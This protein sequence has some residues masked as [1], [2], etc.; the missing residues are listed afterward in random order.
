MCNLGPYK[1]KRDNDYYYHDWPISYLV[2]T[3]RI[4]EILF[5]F[6]TPSCHNHIPFRIR[7]VNC[8]IVRCF[9]IRPQFRNYT[10]AQFTRY[11]FASSYRLM[12]TCLFSRASLSSFIP[13]K[14]SCGSLTNVGLR[15]CMP[16]CWRVET[17]SE[18]CFL[19]ISFPDST[20][21]SCPHFRMCYVCRVWNLHCRY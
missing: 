1:I 12:L 21:N 20:F 11:I 3:R 17:T 14:L 4:F 7:F 13:G 10:F 9:L 19:H 6:K 2:A 5:L 18:F 15:V 16:I 8:M